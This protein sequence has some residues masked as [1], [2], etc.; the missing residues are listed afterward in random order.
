MWVK[1]LDF[2]SSF[3]TKLITS[4]TSVLDGIRTTLYRP[5]PYPKGLGTLQ[6]LP[7]EIR[8]Q[9]FIIV[10]EDYFDELNHR[11]E[12]RSE[13]ESSLYEYGHLSRSKL[14][15]KFVD[16]FCSCVRNNELQR[17]TPFG[18]VFDLASYCRKPQ[19]VGSTPLHLRDA[20]LSVEFVFDRIF[21]TRSTFVF[22]CPT[23][24][25]KFL[26]QL[27][28]YQQKQLRF[29]RLCMFE[30]KDC[31][32]RWR[33][34]LMEVCAFLPPYISSVEIVMPV[35]FV[36]ILSLRHGPRS[37]VRSRRKRPLEY[38]VEGLQEFCEEAS[39]VVPQARILLSGLEECIKKNYVVSDAMLHEA[40]PL[41]K[42]LSTWFQEGVVRSLKDE[43]GIA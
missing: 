16:F 37:D 19:S 27:R 38:T 7:Y 28:P 29:L 36:S 24:M 14:K 32:M 33:D 13:G 30:W 8:A 34:R 35:R 20:S 10:L 43:F 25:K 11:R 22:V 42:L 6:V 5:S 4:I 31:Q 1:I 26:D 18:N 23:T 39:R 21:L 9:I 41:R 15:Y 2:L 3:F 40:E 17:Q 12:H